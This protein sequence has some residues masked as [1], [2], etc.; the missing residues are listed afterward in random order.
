[1]FQISGELF[2][3]FFFMLFPI[4]PPSF[5]YPSY[6]ARFL[7]FI[8]F[9]PKRQTRKEK[10]FNFFS[11]QKILTFNFFTEFLNLL[12]FCNYLFQFYIYILI[13]E[14]LLKTFSR[15]FLMSWRER[16]KNT[17]YPHYNLKCFVV[18]RHEE[19]I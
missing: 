5:F 7:P 3:F 2:L 15:C 11:T 10:L 16:P 17:V 19:E 9:S 14:I 1:M 12:F 8:F 6:L 4:F 13:F 18:S